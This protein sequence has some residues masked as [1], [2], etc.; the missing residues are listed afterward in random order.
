MENSFSEI[1]APPKHL[2]DTWTMETYK[3]QRRDRLGDV[4]GDY[5]TDENTT[6]GEFYVEL[7]AEIQIWIDYH[8]GFLKKA[9]E[10]QTIING[11]KPPS[12]FG[13]GE[14]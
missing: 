6:V 12:E 3:N 14:K 5:L 4:I 9:E 10:M 13:L 8:R 7:R 2:L 11:H 1:P